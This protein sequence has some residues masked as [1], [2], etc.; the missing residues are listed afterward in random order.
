MLRFSKIISLLCNPVV[1]QL[2]IRL[3][4]PLG[5]IVINLDLAEMNAHTRGSNGRNRAT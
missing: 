5:E 1:P 2:K 3:N 4:I